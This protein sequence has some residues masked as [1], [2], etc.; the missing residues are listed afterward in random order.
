MHIDAQPEEITGTQDDP[1]ERDDPILNEHFIRRRAAEERL[2][3]QPAVIDRFQRQEVAPGHADNNSAANNGAE[4]RS[5]SHNVGDLSENAGVYAPFAS[6]IDWEVAKWAKTRGPGSNALDEL[7][8]IDGVRLI[9]SLYCR[10]SIYWFRS[11]R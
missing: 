1:N 6:R 2:L 7:L 9:S 3:Y 5:S 8:A 10:Y 11:Y 4:F